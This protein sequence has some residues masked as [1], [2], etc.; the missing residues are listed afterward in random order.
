MRPKISACFNVV[1]LERIR[2]AQ[3]MFDWNKAG[4]GDRQKHWIKVKNRRHRAMERVMER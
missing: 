1:L 2:I 4:R 3:I